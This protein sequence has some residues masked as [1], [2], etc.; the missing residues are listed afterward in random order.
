M[1]GTKQPMTVVVEAYMTHR[2]TPLITEIRS[3][4]RVRKIARHQYMLLDGFE[5]EEQELKVKYGKAWKGIVG[6][7]ASARKVAALARKH[8]GR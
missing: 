1:K 8:R 2:N 6:V 4:G 7:E 5:L 3:D